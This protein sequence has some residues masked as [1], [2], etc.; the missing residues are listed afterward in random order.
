MTTTQVTITVP[1]G[2][3]PGM[4]F[5]IDWGGM[6]YNIAVPDSVLGGQDIQIELPS[7][8]EAETTP[9]MTAVTIIVP[10]GLGPGSEFAVDW[11][12]ISYIVAVPDGVMAGQEIEIELPSLDVAPAAAPAP[13]SEDSSG[14]FSLSSLG[15]NLDDV[16]QDAIEGEVAVAGCR[17]GWRGPQAGCQPAPE[18][19]ASAA[20]S[21]CD[22]LCK[23][24]LP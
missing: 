14:G 10:E 23:R 6:N 3:S 16:L 5:S 19:T 2:L 12:G 11:G 7:L 20:L 18:P 17:R 15:L 13:T 1:D 4:E 8:D 21:L 24:A 22:F 9:G